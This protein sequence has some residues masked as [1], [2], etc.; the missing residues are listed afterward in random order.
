VNHLLEE[1]KVNGYH[2]PTRPAEPV[3]TGVGISEEDK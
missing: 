2:Q 3:R 1:I